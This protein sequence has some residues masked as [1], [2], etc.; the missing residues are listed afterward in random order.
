MGLLVD[1]LA[2]NLVS[3]EEID[4][5]AFDPRIVL[6]A[7]MDDEAAS[8]T[9]SDTAA[10]INLVKRI[11]KKRSFMIGSFGR[12]RRSKSSLMC[13]YFFFS[14]CSVVIWL[15]L[16]VFLKI[17]CPNSLVRPFPV[18]SGGWRR[19]GRQNPRHLFFFNLQPTKAL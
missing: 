3:A 14:Q 2:M 6:T 16:F 8:R 17:R 4:I 10:V 7:L 5:E 9:P 13:I 18:L 15:G 12:S 1:I 19:G 11:R